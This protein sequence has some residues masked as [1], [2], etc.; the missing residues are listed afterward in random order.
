MN[1]KLALGL[2]L[3]AGLPAVAV[4]Q[5]Y[6]PPKEAVWVA[7]DFRFHSGEVMAEMKLAYTTIGDPSGAPV[8]IL[9]GTGGS[10]GS[11]LNPGF[12]GELFGPGQPLDAAKQE[13][14]KDYNPEPDLAR[15]KAPLLLI[16]SADDERNPP[17]TGITERALAKVPGA[18]LLLIPASK[19]TRGHGTTGMAKFWKKELE[20]FLAAAPRRGP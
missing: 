6:P 16:N 2:V 11:M 20:T 10:A 13:S 9:H 7:K 12:A 18:R 5:G 3:A 4:A 14:S 1:K 8:L 19:D 15:I 17:E